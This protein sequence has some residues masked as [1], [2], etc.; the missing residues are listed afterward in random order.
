MIVAR[1][2][3]PYRRLVS[4]PIYLLHAVLFIL[5]NIKIWP[6]SVVIAK[7]NHTIVWNSF[8]LIYVSIIIKI[9]M[10][11]TLLS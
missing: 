1:F 10:E 7:K 5:V 4:V 2:N 8:L 9:S 3:H 11:F 6:L